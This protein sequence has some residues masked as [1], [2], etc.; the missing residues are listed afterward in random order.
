MAKKKE[1]I[2]T[3]GL[4]ARQ[5]EEIRQ[6]KL[7]NDIEMI[8]GNCAG[9]MKDK[10]FNKDFENYQLPMHERNHVHV[11]MELRLF[12]NMS[13]QRQSV[14][15]VQKFEENSWKAMVD[16]DVFKTYTSEF[17]HNPT[18]EKKN[19]PLVTLLYTLTDEELAAQEKE[20]A[21]APA[22]SP[23]VEDVAQTN[24]PEDNGELADDVV[25]E[26]EM[27]A[28]PKAKAKAKGK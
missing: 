6:R 9:K 2:V 14:A 12:D 15:M 4:T 11:A 27:S 25:E 19:A 24:G 13:G 7:S 10:L 26:P 8:P 20:E 21:L 3:L 5:F 28:K 23:K 16:S 18:L 22:P 1:P 17:I